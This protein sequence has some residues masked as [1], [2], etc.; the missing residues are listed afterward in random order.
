MWVVGLREPYVS[1]WEGHQRTPVFSMLTDPV[2]NRDSLLEVAKLHEHLGW[3]LRKKGHSRP[4]WPHKNFW[5]KYLCLGEN[6]SQSLCRLSGLPAVA[7]VTVPQDVLS[8]YTPEE[9][10]RVRTPP[11]VNKLLAG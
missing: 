8:T 5:L 7:Q 2:L 10:P 9:K 4:I 1:R 11:K 6:G 3:D